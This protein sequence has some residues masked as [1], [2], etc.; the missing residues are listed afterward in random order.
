[1]KKQI[2]TGVICGGIGLLGGFKL[3]ERVIIKELKSDN[4]KRE[5]DKQFNE[6]FGKSHRG[7]YRSFYKGNNKREVDDLIFETRTDAMEALDKL[8]EC[9]NT[10]G[11]VSRADMY[12][13]AG[14]H[15][16]FTDNGYGWTDIS[17][18]EIKMND[19]GY[20]IKMPEA[21]KLK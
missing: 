3:L 6:R 16:N 1:M 11:F 10:Y 21:T 7:V 19:K 8:Q 18:A 5:M 15:S 13:I 14:G 2:I 17:T 4:F 9:I 12:D 20:S